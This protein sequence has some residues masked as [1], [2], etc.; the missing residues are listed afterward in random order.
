MDTVLL[1]KSNV[2]VF[3]MPHES[4]VGHEDVLPPGHDLIASRSRTASEC[5]P[6]PVISFTPNKRHPLE[7]ADTLN[8]RRFADTPRQ[9]TQVQDEDSD[10]SKDS[11]KEQSPPLNEDDAEAQDT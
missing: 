5:L 9:F 4:T 1:N 3:Q 6:S 7:R 8:T 10:T 2:S 11:D